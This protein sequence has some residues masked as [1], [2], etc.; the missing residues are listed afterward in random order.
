MPGSLHKLGHLWRCMDCQ[1]MLSDVR[2]RFEKLRHLRNKLKLL[3]RR[4]GQQAHHDVFQGNYP[5]AQLDQFGLQKS[6]NIPFVANR[7]EVFLRSARSRTTLIVP[8][9]QYTVL[10]LTHSSSL[11]SSHEAGRPRHV[12]GGRPIPSLLI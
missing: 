4:S 6:L 9:R 1:G 7:R 12:T 3:V 8:P 5:N 11:S 10:I 2:S